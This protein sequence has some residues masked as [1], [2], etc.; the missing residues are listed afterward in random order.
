MKHPTSWYSECKMQNVFASCVRL[1]ALITDLGLRCTMPS[2]HIPDRQTHRRS[3]WVVAVFLFF[4]LHTPQSQGSGPPVSL[5]FH[6]ML[7]QMISPLFSPSQMSF[8]SLASRPPSFL[9]SCSL[10][11]LS[12]STKALLILIPLSH[13]CPIYVSQSIQIPFLNAFSL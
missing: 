6:K 7:S 10:L 11:F 2:L 3:L 5:P 1:E 8:F 12:T 9:F 4:F 13:Q